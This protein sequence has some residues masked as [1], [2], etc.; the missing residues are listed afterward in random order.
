M[1]R[2]A[3]Q[4]EVETAVLVECPAAKKKSKHQIMQEEEIEKSSPNLKEFF[5]KYWSSIRSFT[6][7]NKVQSYLIFTTIKV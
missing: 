2:R 7:N 4:I 1:K 5:K 6:R 3:H